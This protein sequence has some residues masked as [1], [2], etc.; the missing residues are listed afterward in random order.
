MNFERNGLS[1]V[2]GSDG[3]VYALSGSGASTSSLTNWEMLGSN[4]VWS[5]PGTCPPMLS[6]HVYGAAVLLGSKIYVMGGV[7]L[8]ADQT[9]NN[10]VEYLDLTNMAAGWQEAAGM[11]TARS[12]F[13]AVTTPTDTIRVFGGHGGPNNTC[14][15]ANVEEYTPGSNIWR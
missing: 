10:I 7:A 15:I 9:S 5:C 6:G 1:M 8:P 14:T 12:Y 4:G 3:N 13:S 2:L 11:L